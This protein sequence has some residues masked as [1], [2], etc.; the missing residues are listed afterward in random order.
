[1]NATTGTVLADDAL[2]APVPPPPPGAL[3]TLVHL[4]GWATCAACL[5]GAIVT[6]AAMVVKHHRGHGV[7]VQP[8]GGEPPASPPAS[9]AVFFL[10]YTVLG[11][12][13]ILFGLLV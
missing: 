8:G 5:V 6:V 4:T 11:V 10:A 1:M 3:L 13:S 7:A 2:Y 9:L 12:V